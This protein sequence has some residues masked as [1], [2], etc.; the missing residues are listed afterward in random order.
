MNWS[1]KLQGV[2]NGQYKTQLAYKN[3]GASS[4][5]TLLFDLHKFGFVPWRHHTAVDTESIDVRDTADGGEGEQGESEGPA[6]YRE[7]AQQQQ[8]QVESRAFLQVLVD[9]DTESITLAIL[10]TGT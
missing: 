8:V 7:Q 2:V 3:V 4:S 5:Q 9:D 1:I 6:Q 10:S